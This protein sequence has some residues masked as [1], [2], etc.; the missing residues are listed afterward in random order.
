MEQSQKRAAQIGAGAYTLISLAIAL[1]FFALASALGKYTTTAIYGGT[2]WAFLL[3]MIVTM[4]TVTP[5]IKKRL[6]AKA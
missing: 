1:A 5:W 4:P 2:A 3:S 6:A